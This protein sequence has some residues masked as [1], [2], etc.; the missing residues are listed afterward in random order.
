MNVETFAMRRRNK[1]QRFT[2]GDQRQKMLYIR[3]MTSELSWRQIMARIFHVR[4]IMTVGS[5]VALHDLNFD[6][7]FHYKNSV[8][9]CVGLQHI[10]IQKLV[11]EY[12]FMDNILQL[13]S[14]PYCTLTLSNFCSV[15]CNRQNEGTLIISSGGIKPFRTEVQKC[16]IWTNSRNCGIHSDNRFAMQECESC[17]CSSLWPD[18]TVDLNSKPENLVKI[19]LLPAFTR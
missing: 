6:F 18:N 2:P 15:T 8:L 10:F 14:I 12:F 13:Y 1:C 7:I 3:T 11:L 5:H 4:P 19:R 16:P 17:Q 9:S